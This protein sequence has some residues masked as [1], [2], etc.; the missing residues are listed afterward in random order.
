MFCGRRSNENLGAL[1]VACEGKISKMIYY[2]TRLRL[3]P[4]D[5]TFKTSSWKLAMLEPT[6]NSV[7]GSGKQ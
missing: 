6:Q 7:N 3:K 1:A 4:N 2:V 5:Y